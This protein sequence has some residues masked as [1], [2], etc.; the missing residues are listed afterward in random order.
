[1]LKD[2]AF[3]A[4]NKPLIPFL[5]NGI[6]IEPIESHLKIYKRCQFDNKIGMRCLMI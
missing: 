2:H 1:M 4:K 3:L 5:R 6:V